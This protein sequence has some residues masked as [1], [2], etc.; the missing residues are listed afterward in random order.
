MRINDIFNVNPGISII[1][2]VDIIADYTCVCVSMFVCTYIASLILEGRGSIRLIISIIWVT[3][4]RSI[5][6]GNKSY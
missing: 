5:R 1:E 4:S 3:R 6:R 2:L